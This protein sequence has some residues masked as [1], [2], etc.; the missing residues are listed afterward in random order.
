MTVHPANSAGATFQLANINGP[1]HGMIAATTPTGFSH[2][3]AR[4]S[5]LGGVRLNEWEAVS[6]TGVVIEYA[7]EC[8]DHHLRE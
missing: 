2:E 4:A 5:D 3:V 1:F 8:R 6:Q 7:R